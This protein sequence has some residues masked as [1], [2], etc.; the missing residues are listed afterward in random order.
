M[1]R[2]SNGVGDLN[3]FL[4]FSINWESVAFLLEMLCLSVYMKKCLSVIKTKQ[5]VKS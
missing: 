2:A 5:F 1:C 4:V 3:I